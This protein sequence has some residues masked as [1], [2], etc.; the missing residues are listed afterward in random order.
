MS[1]NI[2]ELK[3]NVEKALNEVLTKAVIFHKI[4]K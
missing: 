1:L 4:L 3:E 2:V